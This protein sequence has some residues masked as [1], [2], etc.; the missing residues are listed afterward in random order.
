MINNLAEHAK[1]GELAGM[2]LVSVLIIAEAAI[3]DASDSGHGVD[4]RLRSLI[5]IPGAALQLSY[6]LGRVLHHPREA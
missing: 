6:T 2:S 1:V 5:R 3:G 4:S